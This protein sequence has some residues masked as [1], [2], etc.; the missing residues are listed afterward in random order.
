MRLRLLGKWVVSL[1]FNYPD[2]GRGT[3]IESCT[4]MWERISH[5]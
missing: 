1:D 3:G 4:E 5:Y 2:G